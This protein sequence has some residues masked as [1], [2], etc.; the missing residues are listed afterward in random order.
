MIYF[1]SISTQLDGSKTDNLREKRERAET[2]AGSVPMER[3]WRVAKR[4]SV[5]GLPLGRPTGWLDS[6]VVR[7]WS[8][9]SVFG[10][11]IPK[12]KDGPRQALTGSEQINWTAC[13]QSGRRKL[14][15]FLNHIMATETIVQLALVALEGTER[16]WPGNGAQLAERPAS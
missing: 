15:W 9:L 16:R 2:F 11:S 12:A 3:A 13:G 1:A 7:Y 14:G 5:S 8:S 6:F 4:E 10:N